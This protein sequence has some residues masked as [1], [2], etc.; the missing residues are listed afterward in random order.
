MIIDDD[1]DELMRVCMEFFGL[2]FLDLATAIFRTL[3]YVLLNGNSLL[4]NRSGVSVCR[5]NASLLVGIL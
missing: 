5:Y 4:A 1:D 2:M 3:E